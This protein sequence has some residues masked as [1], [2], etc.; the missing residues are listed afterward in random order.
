M[1]I[2]LVRSPYREGWRITPPV[3]VTTGYLTSEII[4][5]ATAAVT[6][7]VLIKRDD[8]DRLFDSIGTGGRSPIVNSHYSRSVIQLNADSVHRVAY[9]AAVALFLPALFAF[10]YFFSRAEIFALAA[11]LMV[12]FLTAGLAV[13]V[14]RALAHLAF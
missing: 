10:Q 14:F 5:R 11:A 13:F 1:M 8:V 2:E 7:T 12:D 4:K 9:F 3:I 6:A